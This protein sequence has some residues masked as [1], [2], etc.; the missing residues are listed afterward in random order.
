MTSRELR[1]MIGVRGSARTAFRA[2]ELPVVQGGTRMERRDLVRLVGV[3][4][5]SAVL[6]W[7]IH[8]A[9]AAESTPRFAYAGAYTRDA[10]GGSSGGAA[11]QGISVLTVDEK[12]GALTLRDTVQSDN[13]SFLA[14][15]PNGR[16]LYA[17]NEVKDYQGENAGSVEA[18]AVKDSDG[19]LELLNRQALSGPIPAHL[20]VDPDGQFLVVALYMGGAFDVLPIENDGSLGKVA[21]VLQQSGS[22]PN[23]K[24]Q[25]KPHPHAVT[26]DPAGRFIA[27]AD[28]GIDK[29]EILRLQD[30]ELTRIDAV[31]LPPG[32]GPRHVAF[33]PSARYLYVI[34]ELQATIVGWQYDAGNGT[35]G[36]EIA[37]VLTVPADFP[38]HRSTAE[39]AVHPSGKFLYGSNR[40]FV[41]RPLADSIVAF[42][43]DDVTGGLSLIGHTTEGI[44]FPRAF[45]LDPSGRW[46]YALNQKGDTIEQFAI[47]SDDGSLEPTGHVTQLPTPVS[48]VFKS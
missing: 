39:I 43:I 14:L 6:P 37:H 34:N 31:S 41:D 11:A 5:L 1:C 28:L 12:T 25:E 15:H 46:L 24:R 33:H 48:L 7:P 30:G 45:K 2:G 13:P 42:A 29:V 32:S 10:P 44:A 35:I 8:R 36:P 23:A 47:D 16:Y 21:T 18:Y 17:I 40:K 22:G 19:S 9:R 26:Y 3:A 38:E 20:A 4:G 27:V